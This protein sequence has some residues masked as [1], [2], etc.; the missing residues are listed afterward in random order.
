MDF[1]GG[2]GKMKSKTYLML[3]DELN[4]NNYGLCGK[5]N[6]SR[7]FKLYTESEIDSFEDFAKLRHKDFTDFVKMNMPLFR[8]SENGKEHVSKEDERI[9]NQLAY[10]AVAELNVIA[11]KY[12]DYYR[13]EQ[14]KFVDLVE[15]I[16]GKTKALEVGSGRIPYSSMLLAQRLGHIDSMDKFLLSDKC[17]EKLNIT[18]HNE[19]FNGDTNIQ[20]FDIIVGKKPCSAIPHIVTNCAIRKKPY[21]IELCGCDAPNEDVDNW[22][23]ILKNVD[24]NIK[25]EKSTA[26]TQYAYNLEM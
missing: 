21:F 2:F 4:H 9:L 10:S 5:H 14:E 11:G 3:I 22:Q 18:P 23:P 20:P 24:P 26:L 6:I 15:H 8:D 25:F 1:I 7:L 17:L 12:F 13:S 16:I 19:Y